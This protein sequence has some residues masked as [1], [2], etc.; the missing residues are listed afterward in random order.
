MKIQYTTYCTCYICYSYQCKK[1]RPTKMLITLCARRWEKADKTF[2]VFSPSPSWT[3]R[4]NPPK[5]LYRLP[6]K[7][8]YFVRSVLLFDF[9]LSPYS[10]SL[11]NSFVPGFISKLF[12]YST[13][14][15]SYWLITCAY[16]LMSQLPYC[17]VRTV[18]HCRDSS[19]CG[20]A[21]ACV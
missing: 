2:L 8:I 16:R 20:L 13:I 14:S 12:G 3:P 9:Q 5:E 11:L 7:T 4:Y 21:S 6:V 19:L 17:V 15:C 1:T 18:R 10:Y